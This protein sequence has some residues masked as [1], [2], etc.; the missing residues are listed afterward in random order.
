MVLNTRSR[1]ISSLREGYSGP[2]R[3]D[4]ISPVMWNIL[5][6]DTNFQSDINL[7][8]TYQ[9]TSSRCPSDV[10]NVKRMSFWCLD[11]NG[12]PVRPGLSGWLSSL[13][14]KSSYCSYASWHLYGLKV[15]CFLLAP[16]LACVEN[17]SYPFS[18]G[19]TMLNDGVCQVEVL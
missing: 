2:F 4:M 14:F 5:G 19:C 15:S 16:L 10:C 9:W 7:P 12:M 13:Q 1:S 3:K 6:N 17:S 8:E 11:V 18:S